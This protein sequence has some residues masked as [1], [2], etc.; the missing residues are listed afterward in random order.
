MGA[1]TGNYADPAGSTLTR[2][3]QGSGN[4]ANNAGGGPGGGVNG[5]TVG[6]G[7]AP[8]TA[9]N[10][11]GIGNPMQRWMT[12]GGDSGIP[13][14]LGIGSFPLPQ[15]PNIGSPVS[16][17]DVSAANA[18]VGG[19]LAQQNALIAAL[20]GQGA[21]DAQSA[22]GSQAGGVAGQLGGI[23]GAGIQNSAAAQQHTMNG[24][25]GVANGV[26]AQQTALG[27]LA[28]ALSGQ[29]DI[30]AGRGP[31]PAQAMLNNATG[32]NVANQAAL[33]AGQRGAGANVGLMAR[34]AAQQGAA[35]QQQAVGQG[36][37]LQ[38][39]QQL[40]AL[41]AQGA[42]AGQQG[43]I[44]A[45]LTGQQQAGIG[46]EFGQGQGITAQQLQALG[47]GA[48]IAQSQVGNL[49]GATGTGLQGALTN[50]GQNMQALGAYNSAVTQGQ[51]NVNTGNTALNQTAM[52]GRQGIGG[53][54][55]A[56]LGAGIATAL[57]SSGGAAAAGGGGG[58]AA[59]G[60]GAGIGSAGGASG[61]S[62]IAQVPIMAAARGGAVHQMA[63]GGTAT[64]QPQFTAVP[65][66]PNQPQSSFGKMLSAFGQ[67]MTADQQGQ[68]GSAAALSKGSQAMTSGLLGALGARGG[69]AEGGG[70]V[71]AKTPGQ[72]ATRPGNSYAND[73]V[74]AMLSE[75]EVVI[76]R[77]VMQAPDPAA[78]AADFVR[79]VIARRGKAS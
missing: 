50:S 36:A 74:P 22:L 42:L 14:A 4:N 56:G 39:Q 24:Q 63:D 78:A 23:Y 58:G 15:M 34:Q 3:L 48:G 30:A 26:G 66:D 77:E 18:G 73:K 71:R 10:A 5:G 16:P 70:S 69:L 21:I 7:T 40:N 33:M 68:R 31:N 65:Q 37:A 53:G 79:Q 17:T 6:Q 35:T 76:P 41:N 28:T 44:G 62:G 27:N 61:A 55:L 64:Q 29:Q 72:H 45:G 54:I 9:G 47:L 20:R 46:Q 67:S 13:N 43:M 52:Q 57:G 49:M 75:G 25:L 11:V 60:A 8:T 12:G 51:G 59:S 1:Q 38:S 19:S 2:W 32:Q